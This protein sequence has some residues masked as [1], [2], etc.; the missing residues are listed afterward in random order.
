MGIKS[1]RT[2]T[3]AELYEEAT[4]LV[5]EEF[6]A[7]KKKPLAAGEEIKTKELAKA[8]SNSVLKEMKII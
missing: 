1:K 8:I 7:L 6:Q 5:R 2:Y 4:R 3:V